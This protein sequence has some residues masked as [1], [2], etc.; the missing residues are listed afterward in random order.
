ME[1]NAL[2]V[3]EDYKKLATFEEVIELSTI[4]YHYNF[5]DYKEK[6]AQIYL[7]LDLNGIVIIVEDAEEGEI[8]VEDANRALA[9]EATHQA[10]KKALT[11]ETVCH[12]PEE[13]IQATPM[14][15]EQAQAFYLFLACNFF[16]SF[17]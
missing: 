14:L 13:S 9:E 6:I 2:K 12:A 7:D 4:I 1:A 16:F 5:N 15:E 10:L 3:V 17:C 8:L 11:K